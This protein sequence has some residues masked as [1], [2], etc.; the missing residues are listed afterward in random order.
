MSAPNFVSD[1][2]SQQGLVL[3]VLFV[4]L[5]SPE[6]YRMTEPLIGRNGLMNIVIHGFVLVALAQLIL[7][8]VSTNSILNNVQAVDSRL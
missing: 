3:V 6:T 4:I 1:L 2:F 8:Y 7:P 5:S